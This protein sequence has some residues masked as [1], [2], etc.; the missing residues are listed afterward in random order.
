MKLLIFHNSDGKKEV[1]VCMGNVAIGLAVATMFAWGLWAVF[2][3]LATDSLLPE[4]AMVISYT[5]GVFVAGVYVALQ[6]ESTQL[7]FDGVIF[8]AL[9]GMASATGAITLYMGLEKGDASVITTISALYFVIS[10]IIGIVFLG[11]SLH[12]TDVVG[13]FLAAVSIILIAN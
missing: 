6:N 10:A 11:E 7:V 2:A 4:T 9:A 12:I 13:I 5:V 3:K 8:A 1:L